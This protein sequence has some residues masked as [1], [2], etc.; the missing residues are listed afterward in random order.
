MSLAAAIRR[1]E[2]SDRNSRAFYCKEGLGQPA[3]CFLVLRRHGH[4]S[5]HLG[6]V[7][8]II[9]VPSAFLVPR[10]MPANPL[11]NTALGRANV[12]IHTS[13]ELL[14]PKRTNLDASIVL[15][16]AN[17]AICSAHGH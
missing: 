6:F 9:D 8:E 5:I 7:Q 4:D 16:L 14:A 3:F 1:S 11:F 2:P 10:T 13:N 17:N 12:Y 15:Q